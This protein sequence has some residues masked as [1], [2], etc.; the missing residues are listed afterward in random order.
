MRSVVAMSS[1][2]TVSR[3]ISAINRSRDSAQSST[4]RARSRRLRGRRS[5]SRA[6]GGVCSSARRSSAASIASRTSPAYF[7][8]LWTAAARAMRRGYAAVVGAAARG[9]G[10]RCSAIRRSASSI[11]PTGCGCVLP[12]LRV[13]RVAARSRTRRGA[14]PGCT[15]WRARA[16]VR[17]RRRRWRRSRSA[18]GAFVVLR[19]CGTPCSSPRRRGCRGCCGPSSA[20]RESGA[21]SALAGASRRVDGLALLAGGWSMLYFGARGASRVDR[22][23]RR[24]RRSRLDAA[25][26]RARVAASALARRGARSGVALAAAQLLPGAARTPRLSPRALGARLR[27]SRR[28]YAWPS[29]RYLVDAARARRCSATTRAAPTSARPISGSCAATRVGVDRDAAGARSRSLP[30]ERRG[31]RI[32]LL[33][34]LR[35]SPSMLARGAGGRCI[36]SL[37]R[38]LPFYGSLRCPARALYVWTLAAPLLAADGLDALAARLRVARLR[39]VAAAR[40]VVALAAE[41]LCHLARR[42]PVDAAGRGAARARAAADWLASTAAPAACVNDVHLGA[43][44]PQRRPARGASRARSATARCRSGATCTFCGSPTTA[45]SIRTRSSPTI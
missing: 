37:F 25:D 45:R 29:W 32:A 41:L 17:A 4:A 30:R 10:S 2:R 26:A 9:A 6:G 28:S 7:E 20:T 23:A 8:P 40:C 38:L 18:L 44:L 31:E 1:A 19:G 33:V 5:W 22:R 12:P 13:V 14:R 24:A 27:R 11:R 15:R 42:E 16:G 34:A 39:V 35:C 3:R 36:R 21:S 43:A